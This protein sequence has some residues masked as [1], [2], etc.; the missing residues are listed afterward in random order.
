MVIKPHTQTPLHHPKDKAKSPAPWLSVIIT[1]YNGEK[2]LSHT[3]H[4]ITIQKE[5]SIECIVIDDSSTDSTLSILQDYKSLL[6]ITL[7]KVKKNGN[8]VTNTNYA[9]SIARGE[10]ACL[11]HQDDIWL[12]NRLKICKEL[13]LEFPEIIFFI[14]PSYFIDTSGNNLGIWRCPLPAYPNVVKPEI[15]TEKL[16]IQNFISI[17]APIF[18]REFALKAGGLDKNLWYT[19]DWDFWLKISSYGNILYYPE[20][21]ACFRVHPD[22]QTVKRSS[23]IEDFQDQLTQVMTRHWSQWNAPETIKKR[24]YK[25]A[26]FS[27][28]VNT[29]LAGV[30]HKKK[31]KGMRLLIS[32]ILLGPNEIFRFFQDSRIWERVVA[33]LKANLLAHDSRKPIPN[34]NS[35]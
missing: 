7:V 8:W 1:T 30:V 24:I 20:P 9:L 23:Y 12:E 11:L 34:G 35:K 33:R 6:P 4:S 16:L 21:L 5:K 17:P 31:M 28:E 14:H 25:T 29:F 15:M 22:S 18:K 10:Y 32:L 27:I 26:S 2:Y 3:L 13:T 19:A